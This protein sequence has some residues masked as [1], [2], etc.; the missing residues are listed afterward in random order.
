MTPCPRPLMTSPPP[1]NLSYEDK[2]LFCCGL[3][4]A[5]LRLL[6]LREVDLVG[7]AEDG[8]EDEAEAEAHMAEAMVVVVAEAEAPVAPLGSLAVD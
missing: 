6:T 1:P 7:V 4:C 2:H 5:G 8:A 3:K